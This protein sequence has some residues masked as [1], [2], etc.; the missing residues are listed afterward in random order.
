VTEDT[1][2]ARDTTPEAISA[3]LREMLRASHATNASLAPARV[4]NLIVIVD[5]EWKGEVANRLE[6]VGRYH[7]SRT[8]ICAV[9]SGRTTVDARATISQED[10]REGLSVVRETVELDIGPDHMAALSTLLDP[11]L[12]AEIPTV[13]WSPHGHIE[14][15]SALLPVIDVIMLDSDAEGDP[16]AAFERA[17][18]MRAEAYV[19]D[20]AWLRT[21]PWRERLAASFH[22]G[23][24]RGYLEQLH[25]LEIRHRDGS[26]ASALLLA[27]WLASRLGWRRAPLCVG[28]SDV[29]LEGA[30]QREGGQVAVTLRR[31]AQEAPGLAGVTVSCEN[32][33]AL[34]L[35]RSLG[36]LDAAEDLPGGGHRE[37]KIL[38]A[39]RGE[40]GILGEGIRQAL[41]REPTYG[42]SLHAA[43]EMCPQLGGNPPTAPRLES[44]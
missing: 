19:V 37:W 32:G 34:S 3:A 6:R 14:A 30:Q 39:S 44:R 15:V 2:A 20:L 24:R 42:P 12:V 26:T 27:G 29:D 33:G 16:G 4:L 9:E 40:A 35:Q 38:G 8:V 22:L 41:L 18:H 43:L 11:V 1:W 28:R 23:A 21:T 5:R 7:A 10:P 13:C 17:E 31:S 36:G 25:A